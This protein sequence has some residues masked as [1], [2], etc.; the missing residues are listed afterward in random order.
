M[1][2]SPPS[3]VHSPTNEYFS[4]HHTQG[5]TPKSSTVDIRHAA[6]Q[7]VE[8]IHQL[9]ADPQL[10]YWTA[11]LPILSITTTQKRFAEPADDQYRFVACAHQEIIGLVDLTVYSAP[12]LHH[13]ARIGSVAVRSDWQRQ[14]VGTQLIKTVVDLA[15]QWLNL[16]RLELLVYADNIAAIELYKKYGF[17]EEGVLRRFAFRAGSYADGLLMARINE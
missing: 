17:Q 7:D 12:R 13:I 10:V 1:L 8:G 4:E 14:G 3:Q 9:L 2:I 11:E 15:D 6:I 16:V 5:Y